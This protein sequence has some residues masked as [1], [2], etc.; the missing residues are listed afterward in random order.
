MKKWRR[1]HDLMLIV[2]NVII[3]SAR[4]SRNNMHLGFRS[5]YKRQFSLCFRILILY[6]Q[7]FNNQRLH[8]SVNILAGVTWY[9]LN[10]NCPYFIFLFRKKWGDECTSNYSPF[11]FLFHGRS[12]IFNVTI[13][14]MEYLLRTKRPQLH[15]SAKQCPSRVLRDKSAFGEWRH[16]AR[17]ERGKC[18]GVR[19]L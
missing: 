16:D 15:L 19:K 10:V 13:Q 12:S 5:K 8:S 18:V 4:I 14:S 7:M 2:M 17:E 11:L 9:T 1:Q 3:S 6:S